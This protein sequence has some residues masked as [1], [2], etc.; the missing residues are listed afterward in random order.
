M[1]LMDTVHDCWQEATMSIDKQRFVAL[2]LLAMVALFAG[3]PVARAEEYPF[4]PYPQERERLIRMP[5]PEGVVWPPRNEEEFNRLLDALPLIDIVLL[6][7]DYAR[8]R[9]LRVQFNGE[10]GGYRYEV[11]DDCR[12][13]L[14]LGYYGGDGYAL[15]MRFLLEHARRSGAPVEPLGVLLESPP[16]TPEDPEIYAAVS[17]WRLAPK[18]RVRVYLPDRF[19]PESVWR[20]GS[21]GHPFIIVTF[22]YAGT[23]RVGPSSPEGCSGAAKAGPDLAKMVASMAMEASPKAKPEEVLQRIREQEWARRLLDDGMIYALNLN[24]WPPAGWRNGDPWWPRHPCPYVDLVAPPDRPAEIY[25]LRIEVNVSKGSPPSEVKPFDPRKTFTP[26]PPLG[27]TVTPQRP[28]E[29]MPWEKA[30]GEAPSPTPTRPAP[31][32][33]GGNVGTAALWLLAGAGVLAGAAALAWRIGLLNIL[34][35]GWKQ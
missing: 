2:L 15:C 30:R 28:A 35:G 10:A 6:K 5:L 21:G 16:G 27:P 12:A 24:A 23:A 33:A 19:L 34:S 22:G 8:S 1:I 18:G 7:Y 20:T 17:A 25:H 9:P 14:I 4:P 32:R 13:G 29:P 3:A 31:Q 26:M 11:F